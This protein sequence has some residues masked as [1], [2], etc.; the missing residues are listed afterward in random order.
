[1]K[2][3]EFEMLDKTIEAARRVELSFQTPPTSVNASK[4]L[5]NR[6]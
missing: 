2:A 1:M 6:K 3:S 4:S 5:V